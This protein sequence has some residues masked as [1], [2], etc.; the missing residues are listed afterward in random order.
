M[1][2]AGDNPYALRISQIQNRLARNYNGSVNVPTLYSNIDVLSNNRIIII[3]DLQEWEKGVGLLYIVS[4]M[5]P[6][7]KHLHLFNV[8]ANSQQLLNERDDPF[9]IRLYVFWKIY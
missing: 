3:K 7:N 2:A 4:S 6:R 5:F 1:S 9:N 8:H